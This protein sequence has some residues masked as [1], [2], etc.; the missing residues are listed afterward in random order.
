MKRNRPA[1]GGPP[2]DPP[3]KVQVI[4]TA[5][6]QEDEMNPYNLNA[7]GVNLTTRIAAQ[8]ATGQL[9]MA[10][11][12]PPPSIIS[13]PQSSETLATKPSSSSESGYQFLFFAYFGLPPG[14]EYDPTSPLVALLTLLEENAQKFSEADR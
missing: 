4:G 2:E 7:S 3:A 9:L 6:E 1:P 11:A 10:S 8:E 14:T 12:S 5:L 13:S